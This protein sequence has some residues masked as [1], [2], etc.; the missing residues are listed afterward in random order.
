MTNV[1]NMSLG[2]NPDNLRDV[3]KDPRY[4][5]VKADINDE[6][7]L[8]DLV[9]EVDAVI[10]VAAQTHVDRSIADPWPFIRS[11]NLGVANLLE[12]MRRFN[13]D[14]RFLQVSTD[15]VYGRIQ[16]RVET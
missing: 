14:V 7:V 4:R 6:A 8:R 16:P 10:N 3:E 12:L 1:D 11:N 15:E 5:F 9:R 13:D 2:S